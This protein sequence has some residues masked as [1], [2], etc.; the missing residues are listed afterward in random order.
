ML[1][2]TVAYPT[3]HP[4]WPRVLPVL[5][6]TTV[7]TW[8]AGHSEGSIMKRLN[9]QEGARFGRLT[10]LKEVPTH[11]CPSGQ[12]KRRFR[13]RCDCGIIGEYILG[14]LRRRQTESCGC[15]Q[16]ERAAKSNL[17]HGLHDSLEYGI[18]NGMIMRCHNPN[19]QAFHLYG[20]RGIEVCNRWRESFSAFYEDMGPRP[21]SDRSI[22]R[23]DGDK[24]YY[25]ANCRWATWA[26]QQRNRRNNRLLTFNGRTLCMSKWAEETGLSSCTIHYRLKRGWTVE[27][28]LTMPLHCKIRYVRQ[29]I[30]LQNSRDGRVAGTTSVLESISPAPRFAIHAET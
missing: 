26:D 5:P 15:L 9:I 23:I 24:G 8:P 30:Q 3:K 29:S 13:C 28:T 19:S 1:G 25:Q 6:A 14:G 4:R 18:W 17:R 7:T 20:G 11:R 12:T 22:H 21:S 27:Q 16:K 2:V 10:V